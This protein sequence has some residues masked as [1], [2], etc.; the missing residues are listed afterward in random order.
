MKA[1]RFCLCQHVE[2]SHK[3]G[4]CRTCGCPGFRAALRTLDVLPPGVVY[5]KGYEQ[6]YDLVECNHDLS[7]RAPMGAGT[8]CVFCKVT[9]FSHPVKKLAYV[10]ASARSSQG[11]L[12]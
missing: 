6:G 5:V 1:P 3:N 9:E 7:F 11:V 8:W 12:L 10:A 2:S 4:P